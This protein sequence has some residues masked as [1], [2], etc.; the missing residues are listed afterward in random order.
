MV[1]MD[2]EG[3]EAVDDLATDVVGEVTGLWGRG[4]K[5]HVHACAHTHTQNRG[6][7]YYT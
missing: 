3:P 4:E 1:S 2:A 7:M 6:G 5:T